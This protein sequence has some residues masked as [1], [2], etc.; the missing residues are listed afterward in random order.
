MRLLITGASGHISSARRKKWPVTGRSA[1][2]PR[3][4]RT[5]AGLVALALASFALGLAE[6]VIAGL[7]PS[8]SRDLSVS[9]GTA[10]LLVTTYAIGVI[11]GALV[12]T[13]A[14][15]RMRPKTALIWLVAVFAGANLLCALG[16]D[17]GIVLIAR[18]IAGTAHGAYFGIGVVVAVSLVEET[19]KGRAIAVMLTGLTLAN[20]LGV[21]LGTLVGQ[22]FGWRVTFGV[23]VALAVAAMMAI[24][25]LVPQVAPSPTSSL[26]DLRQ[27]L[28]RQALLS[29]A[30]ATLGFGG[31]FGIFTYLAFTLTRVTGYASGTVPWLLLL[32]GV[33]LVIGN[34]L[35]GRLADRALDT[36]LA[37]ALVGLLIVQV[38]F[39]L[40]ASSEVGAA[41]AIFLMG[42]FGFAAAPGYQRRVMRSA[43]AA[44]AIASGAPVAAVNLGNAL[45]S[46]ID[47]L[48][49]SDG[50]GYVSPIWIGAVATGLALIL[51]AVAARSLR[52]G[53][54]I[55][56]EIAEPPGSPAPARH[57]ESHSNDRPAARHG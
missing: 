29:M 45:G 13:T 39:G 12:V 57:D 17:F 56:P 33:G 50:L 7:L 32:F 28:N 19:R 20:V 51:L 3:A 42:M 47:G 31:M 55:A 4:A 16:P 18:V 6:F 5:P 21:P 54:T 49:I 15:S 27:L 1:R 14:L 34:A 30:I 24:I 8:V 40:V 43:V 35:G 2:T 46:W 48:A 22:H 37:V 11:V 9:G 38:A 10:G 41:V 36:T 26:A 53:P 52:A 44:G 23:I 25:F